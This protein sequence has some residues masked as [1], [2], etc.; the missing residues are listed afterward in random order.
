M[1]SKSTARLPEL[2]IDEIPTSPSVFKARVIGLAT[3][4]VAGLAWPVWQHG[5]AVLK[6]YLSDKVGVHIL[7]EKTHFLGIPHEQAS[8][9]NL[10]HHS[11]QVIGG[12]GALCLFAGA[13]SLILRSKLTLGLLKQTQWITLLVMLFYGMLTWQASFTIANTDPEVVGFEWERPDAFRFWWQITWPAL[14]LGAYAMWLKMMLRSRQVYA[15][16]T[17]R[18]GDAMAGDAA[19]ENIRT[20]GRDTRHR[21]ALYWSAF[22]HLFFIVLLPWLLGLFGPKVDPYQI[23]KGS[24]NPVVAMVKMVKPKKKKKK[25][26]TLRANSAIIY[27]QPDLD[28]TEVD[29]VMEK[30]T[31][32]TYDAAEMA[33]VGKLGK[34]GGDDGGWPQGALDAKVRFIRLDHGGKGWDDGM[35]KSGADTNF[36]KFFA[37]NT[38]FKKIATKGEAHKI[39]LLKKYPDDGFPPF[40]YM[41]GNGHIPRVSSADAKILR[42]YCLKG[43]MLVG[44][45]GS[46]NF[47]TS[48]TRLMRQVFPDKPLID[49]ADDDMIYQLP[50][51]FPNGA[52]PLFAH[53]GR[54]AMGIKHDGRWICFYHPGDLNDAWKSQGYSDVE[55]EVRDAAMSLGVNIIYY[56]F[57][58]WDDAISKIRRNQKNSKD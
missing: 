6:Q 49:I 7:W 19:L 48:F 37:Q 28:E 54:R 56:A 58:Q 38:P 45:A 16:F 46:R 20:H 21:K 4:A 12:L 53:G 1:S 2:G 43:G 8:I 47:H 22:T 34:G 33:K 15:A 44:D 40:V 14:A 41:T 57:N 31:Q 26:L 17:G 18:E 39:S 9:L 36:L 27:D 5:A 55:P 23:P 32:L 51:A 11:F 30:Q 10:F 42:E 13:L 24:G 25:T 29:Q 35:G 50:Y 3:L 52:P